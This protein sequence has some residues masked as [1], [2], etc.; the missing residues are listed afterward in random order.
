GRRSPLS[1]LTRISCGGDCR[2]IRWSATRAPTRVRWHEL[3]ASACLKCGGEFIPGASPAGLCP[4]CLLTTALSSDPDI[5]MDLSEDAPSTLPPG[6]TVGP[7]QL[8]RVL[9]R[10]GMAAV[11]E[12]YD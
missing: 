4:A 2:V 11:Y 8:V 9:G 6:T 12:A 7:F 1:A 10:G 5:D 3:T